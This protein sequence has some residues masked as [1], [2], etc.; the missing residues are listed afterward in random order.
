MPHTI[1]Q[2]PT[3]AHMSDL[4]STER[5]AVEVTHA[6]TFPGGRKTNDAN[7][8]YVTASSA[9][10]ASKPIEMNV[11]MRVSR[12]VESRSISCVEVMVRARLLRF[13]R[14]ASPYS[15]L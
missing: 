12:R 3:C 7:S 9:D 11:T 6:D 15:R 2:N 5:H 8:D 1:V 4:R 13:V 10:V 14:S